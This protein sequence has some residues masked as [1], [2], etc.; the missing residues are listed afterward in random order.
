VNNIA[1]RTPLMRTTN[2]A[3]G[4]T[5]PH[6][7]LTD[8]KIVGSEPI[9]G[10]VSTHLVDPQLVIQPFTAELYDRFL[11]DR[12]RRIRFAIKTAVGAEPLAENT[13]IG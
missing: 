4:N 5:A 10:A 3:I 11:V 6:V 2:A 13:I 12:T 1:N 8:S 9:E 7:Y